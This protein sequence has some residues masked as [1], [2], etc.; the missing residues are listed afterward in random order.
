[1]AKKKANGAG[2]QG[3]A[4]AKG[5]AGKQG[6]A[7]QKKGNRLSLQA[8]RCAAA[9]AGA[10][11][12][13]APEGPAPAVSVLVP[14]YN[15]ER[16][17]EQAL[18]SLLAQT[19]TDFEVLC[20]NDGSSDG[21][22]DIIKRYMANDQRFRLIDK[23]NSGYG[24][25]MNLGIDTA[26]GEYIG[27]LE[28]D[29]FFEPNALELLYGLAKG[30]NDAGVDA[31][32]S[33]STG[34]AAGSDA[35]AAENAKASENAE[36]EGHSDGSGAANGSNAERAETPVD[37]AKAN[38]WFYWSTPKERNQLINVCTPDMAAAPFSP[39]EKSEVFYSIPSIWSA[40]Y[41]REML[42]ECG[43]RFLETAGASFQDLGFQF[44]VWVS[45]QKVAMSEA[46]ILHYRQDNEASSVNDVQKVMCVC[47]EFE[48]AE[49]FIKHDPQREMLEKVLFRL[50]YDS[51]M[52]N[53]ARLAPEQRREFVPVMQKDL[54][55]GFKNGAYDRSLFKDHQDACLRYL[56]QHPKR[57]EQFF[58]DDPTPM[59]KGLFYLLIAGPK[60]ALK[61]VGK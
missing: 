22:L 9:R 37:V 30:A 61:A 21:S 20:I 24:A 19:F 11:I 32:A 34:A 6:A 15:T 33:A 29:D 39:R 52:W 27:I 12:S 38:Y 43:V 18:D 14:I 5:S 16:Y 45:A 44:K 50:R 26:R 2:K 25:S 40:L 23:D 59:K 53:F 7:G 48:M 56:M 57:F 46:P 3:A 42:N 17:L 54:R 8:Q 60:A 4:G 49:R 55:Q 10:K 35:P 36:L 1:M 41:R 31:G 58:P 28:P 47:K 51:Y 13:P